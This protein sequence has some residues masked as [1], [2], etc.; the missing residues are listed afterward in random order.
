MEGV[1]AAGARPAGVSGGVADLEADWALCDVVQAGPADGA[2]RL[3][4]ARD[5]RAEA[6]GVEGV[7]A[8]RLAPTGGGGGVVQTHGA[9][10]LLW[11]LTAAE[12]SCGDLRWRMHGCWMHWRWLF[13]HDLAQ[14]DD[15]RS[16]GQGRTEQQL[17]HA[18]VASQKGVED[19]QIGHQQ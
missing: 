16:S 6:G 19:E 10:F 9:L 17:Q 7:A 5:P 8:P 3:L 13:N 2:R 12:L 1:A 4:L 15:D 18:P 14:R 11:C